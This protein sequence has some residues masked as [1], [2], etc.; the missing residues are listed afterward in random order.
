MYALDKNLAVPLYHQIKNILMAGIESGEWE[1]GQQ[2]PTETSLSERFGVSKITVRQALRDL[3]DLGYI[4]REQGRGT[5]VSKAKLSQGPRE[6]TSFSEEMRRHNLP[7]QTKVLEQR[8]QGA[9]AAVAEALHIA[10][11]QPVIILKRLRIAACEPM[12][13]QTAHIPAGLT[14]GLVELNLENV[15]LYEVLESRYGLFP[16]SARE[17]YTAVL[18]EAEEAALL[19]ID[20]HSAALAVRRVTFLPSGD[21]LELVNSIV[22]GDRYR[23][24]LDLVQSRTR[25]AAGHL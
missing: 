4:R 14:P 21:P 12:G 18:A 7:A 20:L 17:A 24:V 16:A 25:H 15:S 5:F 23:V 1:P 3:V 9:D 2:I 19:G 13:I 10:I 6:L 11:G 22:R 8:I